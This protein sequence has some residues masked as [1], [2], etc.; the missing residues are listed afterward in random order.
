MHTIAHHF[1]RENPTYYCD[2]E[3]PLLSRLAQHQKDTYQKLVTK[4]VQSLINAALPALFKTD[5]SCALSLLEL[6]ARYIL[7]SPDALANTYLTRDTWPL[8]GGYLHLYWIIAE[9]VNQGGNALKAKMMW[10]VIKS[11][12][13]EGSPEKEFATARLD[14][15][16]TENEKLWN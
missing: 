10:Q 3:Y 2:L 16:K 1:A 5:E 7:K 8:V 15:T 13:A 9:Q 12:A 4:R 14:T 6:E 11:K